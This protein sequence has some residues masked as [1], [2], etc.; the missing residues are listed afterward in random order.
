VS[1]HRLGVH[2][3]GGGPSGSSSLPY[4][5]VSDLEETLERVRT[6]GGAA[7]HRAQQWAI[8]KDSEGSPFALSRQA[9]VE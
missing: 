6:L 5:Q 7:I 4:F 1:R 8:C 3:R 2:A 9:I